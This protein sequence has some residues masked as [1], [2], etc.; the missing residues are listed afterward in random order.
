MYAEGS[1][2][3]LWR[4]SGGTCAVGCMAITGGCFRSVSEGEEISHAEWKIFCDFY[5]NNVLRFEELHVGL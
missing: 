4:L 5:Y 2:E 1:E 3:G